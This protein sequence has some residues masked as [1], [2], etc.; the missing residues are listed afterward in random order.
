MKEGVLMYKLVI[1]KKR[2][3]EYLILGFLCISLYFTSKQNYIFFHTIT[4]MA[5]VVLGFTLML[6]SLGTI[7]ICKNDYY[8][9]L[10]IIFGFV[11]VIDLF[12]VFTYKGINIFSNNSNMPTQL[13]IL[14]RYYECIMLNLSVIYINKKINFYKVFAINAAV[15]IISILSITIFNVFP[16]CY[17]E[18]YGL[19][20][21]KKFSEYLISMG[22]FI[23]LFRV[24]KSKRDILKD[25]KSD[26]V[27]AIV[28]QILCSLSFTLYIDVYGILNLFGHLFKILSYYYGFKVM[29]KYIVVNPYSTLFKNL[30]NKVE[31]LE[32]ANKELFKA[33]YKVQS[34]EKL[35]G[36][37]VDFI[38]DGILVLRDK[39]IESA[40]SRFLNM[41]EIDE[42]NKLTNMSI[43]DVVD[44]SYHE[45][46]NSR[47]YGANES[48][49]GVPQQ[50]EFIWGK[51][52]KWFEVSSLIAND[53][54]GKYIISTIRDIE[55]RKKV[56]EAE[57]LLELKKKEEHMKNDFFTNISHEL[58]TPINVMYSALQVERE[59]LKNYNDNK[60]SIVK[61][62][63][64][65]RQNCLRLTRLINNLI[66][67]TRI[68]TSFFK[69]NFRIENIITVVEDITMSITEYVENKKMNL[70]FDTEI[71]EAYVSCD[72][73][74]IERIMLNI[75]SNAVK[76][77][78][79]DGTIE[80]YIC[81]SSIN[82]ISI[83]I[84]DD[85]IGIPDE[86]KQKI[87]NRF[88]KVDN[89]LSRKTEGSGIGLALV[90]QLVEIH[91][92]TIT[93]DSK[94]NCG[95]EFKI[96][97]PTVEYC[98][99][100]CATL[101]KPINYEKNIIQSAEIEFSDIYY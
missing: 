63:N 59:Y 72:P 81:Q 57:Q 5:T 69:P 3:I 26:L 94:I 24:I 96:T 90:K 79:E 80:V 73:D 50:Y 45:I 52:K 66:D 22:F 53:E 25:N 85:G 42:E 34:I 64:I 95:T 18:G 74:I 82:D 51:K 62:N 87:F 40:N 30:N 17:I 86:M 60:E 55:D 54:S 98:S 78:K 21:F 35:F 33:N 10:A 14:S 41:L 27:K 28:L 16:T 77:G 8:H 100:V 36:K 29:F 19:T 101:E 12:H 91:Q 6:I 48:I 65:I 38:P 71:E 67:I 92:G 49:L 99:E 32:N 76:Y 13:W 31:E 61:Y 11:G 9:F 84:K 75:L 2:G 97:L 68:E 39:K 88:L 44:K 46:L 47:L 89:S 7:K 1:N 70:V 23:I 4:E 20:N 15:V 93:F 37:F 83:L 58:R 43:L 56:E